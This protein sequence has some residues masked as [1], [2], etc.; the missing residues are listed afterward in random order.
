VGLLCTCDLEECKLVQQVT[1]AMH[2]PLTIEHDASCADAVY[3]MSTRKA[4]SLL[5]TNH[6]RVVGIVTREDLARAGVLPAAEGRLACACCGSSD[7][8]RDHE[9]LGTMC[10]DCL[11]RA[12]PATPDDETGVVD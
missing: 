12:E 11:R 5:V 7:H 6:E 9:T 8:L 3:L 1:A 2:P 10:L 4:G